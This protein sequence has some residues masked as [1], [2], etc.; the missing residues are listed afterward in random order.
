MV[1]LVLAMMLI[2]VTSSVLAAVSS[3]VNSTSITENESI[4]LKV[5]FSGMDQ[6]DD[7]DFSRLSEGFEFSTPSVSS[8]FVISNGR[9]NASTTWTL[10]LRPRHTGEL[11]IP[12]FTINGEKTEAI[13]VFVEPLSA[14]VR[15]ELEQEVF[16]L[17]N[18][19]RPQQYIHGA[20]HVERRLYYSDNVTQLSRHLPPPDDIENAYVISRGDITRTY[21]RRNNRQYSVLVQKFVLF[22][23]ISGKINIPSISVEARVT[24]AGSSMTFPARS[25]EVNLEILPIPD[26]YP[27]DHPWFPSTR[28][29]ISDNFNKESLDDLKIGDTIERTIVIRAVDNHSS[30]IPNYEFPVPDGV[31]Q[32]IELPD[33][34]DADLGTEIVGTRNIHSTILFTQAGEFTFPSVSI[35]WWN[36]DTH[37]LESYF[38]SGRTVNVTSVEP[39]GTT[40]INTNDSVSNSGNG[41]ISNPNK[42]L[43]KQ[44]AMGSPHWLYHLF[45]V[46]GW[47]SVI[48]L[49]GYVLWI[50]GRLNWIQSG[51]KPV[52][53]LLFLN[54]L[55]SKEPLQIKEGML[56]FVIA[57]KKFT[58][59]Q[60][61]N[62]LQQNPITQAALRK[63]NAQAYGIDE[64]E[65]DIDLVELK[66]TL[67]EICSKNQPQDST[68]GSLLGSW[69]MF[70]ATS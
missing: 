9:Q 26:E 2:G 16:I 55:N 21:A 69:K 5:R 37:K 47:V 10:W 20:I 65:L 6:V 3:S 70:K 19:N 50:H 49:T 1:K 12:P 61:I 62:F 22:P 17:T 11:T 34:D 46:L 38:V 31:R 13:N 18:V 36:T 67:R 44:E 23:E 29:Q 56:K 33:F 27:T 25:E 66:N 39:V 68:I 64:S 24:R 32:Y 51:V 15:A 58:R 7:P 14:E 63:L 35:H 53:N 28:V 57:Q 40:N 52:E 60:A 54:F 41:F 8:R 4:E 42:E 45:F 59:A 48:I 43:G 30:D